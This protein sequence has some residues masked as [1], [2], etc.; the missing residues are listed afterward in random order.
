MAAVKPRAIPSVWARPERGRR[1]L[2]A[3]SRDQIVAE[4]VALLDADGFEALSM[5]KLGARLGAG[6]TSLYTHV[7]N[8]EE[9]L[10]LVVDQV[11]GEIELPAPD[12]VRWRAAAT[13][14][15]GNVRATIL[16]HPW[17]STVL[18]TAGLVYLGPNVMRLSEAILAILETAGFSETDAD[19]AT[20]AMVSYV[21]G[22]STTEAAMLTTVARSGMGEQQ[23][24]DQLIRAG[25]SA[26]TPYPRMHKRYTAFRNADAATARSS[27]FETQLELILDGLEQRAH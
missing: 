25:E 27:A 7:A 13:E 6:A 9:L 2:P 5:R 8:K 1:D 3:L 11:L 23:W 17:I 19:L 26:S 4:A 14:L 10:E 12:P 24:L 21:V 15:L 18:S 16:R 22:A 20:N